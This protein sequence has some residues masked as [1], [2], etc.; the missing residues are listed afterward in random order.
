M[1]NRNTIFNQSARVFSL[2][3]F[4][5]YIR[6]LCWLTVV[7]SYFIVYSSLSVLQFSNFQE[8][9]LIP[10]A[11]NFFVYSFFQKCLEKAEEVFQ[12]ASTDRVISNEHVF[13][14][15]VTA[16]FS[17]EYSFNGTLFLLKGFKKL[18]VSFLFLGYPQCW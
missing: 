11:I 13:V 15:H 17:T 14:S 18:I 9:K 12:R 2:G 1:F 8:E 4:L 7:A 3:H 6:T 16:V 5:I 10:M